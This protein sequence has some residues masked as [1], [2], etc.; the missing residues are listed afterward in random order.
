MKVNIPISDWGDIFHY[1]GNEV[2]LPAHRLSILVARMGDLRAAIKEKVVTD[3]STIV[4]SLLSI[5]AALSEW[6][7]QLPPRWAFST[8]ETMDESDEAYGHQHHLYGD[9]FVA[10]GWN[11]YRCVRI[12]CNEEILA[13][14]KRLPSPCDQ[15]IEVDFGA[16]ARAS[17]SLLIQL[18]SEIVDSVSFLLGRHT[19]EDGHVLFQCRTIFGF[20]MLWPLFLAGSV[21]GVPDAL[22]VWVVRVLDSIGFSMG[23]QQASALA[24]MLQINRASMQS[25]SSNPPEATLPESTVSANNALDE[26]YIPHRTKAYKQF[27]ALTRDR[28][29]EV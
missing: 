23:I 20:Y 4:L 3:C 24:K 10:S 22:H 9:P 28:A 29:V 15:S 19:T 14:I 1:Y 26:V 17:H 5:D 18:A 7:K 11:S 13:Q 6:V 27:A 2:E 8:I 12:L 25:N 21:S 16:Q